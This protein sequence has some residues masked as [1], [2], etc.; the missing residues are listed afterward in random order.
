MT[1][2]EVFYALTGH[3]LEGLMIHE[4]FIDYYDFLAFT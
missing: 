4:Q 2:E 1:G 3:M